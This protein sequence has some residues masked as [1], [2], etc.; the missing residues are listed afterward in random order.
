MSIT[1]SVRSGN[2][3]DTLKEYAHNKASQI[4]EE[5]S[6]VTNVQVILDLEKTRCKAE[7]IVRGKSLDLTT[8]V[9][10]YDMYKSIDGIFEKMSAKLQKEHRKVIEHHKSAP[11]KEEQ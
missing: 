8:Q 5:F 7:A 4:I 9:E 2:I 6:R 10:T 3:S 1:V 11:H